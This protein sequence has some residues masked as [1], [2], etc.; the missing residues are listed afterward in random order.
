MI[1]HKMGLVSGFTKEKDIKKL[2]YYEYYQYADEAIKREK[3][4]KKWNR[5]WK[6]TLIE[7]MNPKWN[8]L[9]EWLDE[10]IANMQNPD[11][12]PDEAFAGKNQRIGAM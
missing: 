3:Q 7:R 2:G 5:A 1:E 10:Y 4:L 9:A 12:M 11:E 8:D 6:Y